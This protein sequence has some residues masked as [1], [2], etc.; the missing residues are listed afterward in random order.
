MFLTFAQITPYC[1]FILNLTILQPPPPPPF[2]KKQLINKSKNHLLTVEAEQKYE[3]HRADLH[4]N[5]G[6][7]HII[8]ILQRQIAY[9]FRRFVYKGVVP[10]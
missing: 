5:L 1:T 7:L 10:I 6:E 3:Y 9:E 8:R 4:S 2:N